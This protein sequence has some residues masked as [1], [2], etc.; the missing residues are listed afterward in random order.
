[1]GFFENELQ[2]IV[3]AKSPIIDARYGGRACVGRLG[4][5][6]NIK[7][8]FVTLGT[9]EKYEG[10]KATVFNRNNGE[11]DSNI[12]RF[13][14]ILGK[15]ATKNNLNNNMPYAWKTMN[16]NYEWY[17]YKP[18]ATDYSTLAKEVNAYLE[19]FLEPQLYQVNEK[20]KTLYL[21]YSCNEW[22][23][24]SKALLLLITP[25]KETL[26]AAIGG[27]ILTGNMEYIGESGGKGFAEYKK[28]CLAG[29]DSVDIFKELNYGFVKEMDITL[30]SEPETLSEYYA[31]ANTL[32]S[33]DVNFDPDAF[34]EVYNN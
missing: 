23:E 16:N 34:D 9:H 25:D 28:D 26:Y 11:I 6:T 24:K 13:A 2:K 18:T 10:I 27:E 14:D 33:A 20:A 29:V 19:M 21:L 1:M 5:T 17:S 32:L 12:F 15:N 30:L 7:L 3:G 8:Q 22:C 31:S 4:E